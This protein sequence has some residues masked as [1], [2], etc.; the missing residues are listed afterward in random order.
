MAMQVKF[1]KLMLGEN[2]VISFYGERVLSYLGFD[3]NKAQKYWI[4]FES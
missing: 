4:T 3:A 1:W 2:L